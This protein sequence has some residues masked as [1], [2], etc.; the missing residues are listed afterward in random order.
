M[1][2]E[3]QRP[4]RLPLFDDD[5]NTEMDL[6]EDEYLLGGDIGIPPDQTMTTATRQRYDADFGIL[7]TDVEKQ[8]LVVRPSWDTNWGSAFKTSEAQTC[9]Y[10]PKRRLFTTCRAFA[11]LG[12]LCI[13]GAWTALHTAGDTRNW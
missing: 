7:E 13:I 9:P 1:A 6:A 12:V 3:D 2:Q 4:I 11:A 8:A 5:W 10:K